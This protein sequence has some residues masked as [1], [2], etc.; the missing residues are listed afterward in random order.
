MMDMLKRALTRRTAY[1]R[2]FLGD[3]GQ[4]TRDG[5]IVLADL[6]KFCRLYKSTTMVSRITQ[7]TDV[8]AT[9]QAE[10]RREV[11]LRILSHLYIDDKSLMRLQEASTE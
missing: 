11:I 3:D 5:E 8:P 7:Q 10:G 4:L 9:F 1:K 2:C 6:E